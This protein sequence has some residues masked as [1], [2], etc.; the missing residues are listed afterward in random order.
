MRGWRGRPPPQLS[1][2]EV[3]GAHGDAPWVGGEY[4]RRC[5]CRNPLSLYKGTTR[6]PPWSLATR[7]AGRARGGGGWLGGAAAGAGRALRAADAV[8]RAA[9][10]RGRRG[11]GHLL[12][13]CRL[14]CGW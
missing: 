14:S 4:N 2:M 11:G 6:K 13:S 5:L 8:G 7:A 12:P 10:L 1:H 3:Q 9:V